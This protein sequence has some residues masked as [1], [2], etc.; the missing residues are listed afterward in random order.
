MQPTKKN[1]CFVIAVL[2]LTA[3]A[4]L[5]TELAACEHI[6]NSPELYQLILDKKLA[7]RDLPAAKVIAITP[8]EASIKYTEMIIK[9]EGMGHPI[10][11]YE[12][13]DSECVHIKRKFYFKDEEVKRRIE[14]L[15]MKIL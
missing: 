14:Q 10:F 13:Y 6:K 8:P 3:F 11:L 9:S 15:E 1:R 4:V 2:I 12:K 7:E 5:P